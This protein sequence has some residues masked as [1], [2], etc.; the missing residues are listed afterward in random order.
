MQASGYPR[1]RSTIPSD[2]PLFC[3]TTK[4]PL[5]MISAALAEVNT[6]LASILDTITAILS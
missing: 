5:D 3:G 1:L 6:V 2:Q 4:G